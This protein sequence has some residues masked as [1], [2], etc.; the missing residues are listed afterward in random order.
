MAKLKY[1]FACKYIIS[2]E[3]NMFLSLQIKKQNRTN[4]CVHPTI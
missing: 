1:T 3:N 2:P 4:H